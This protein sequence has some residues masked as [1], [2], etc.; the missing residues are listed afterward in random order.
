[1][2]PYASSRAAVRPDGVAR[3]ASARRVKRKLVPLPQARAR[4]TARCASHGILPKYV[5][6]FTVSA[7][8]LSANV[9]ARSSS[10]S[11]S[12]QTSVNT[13]ALCKDL[14]RRRA[15][16]E[17]STVGTPPK[18]MNIA[19]DGA[20]NSRAAPRGGARRRARPGRGCQDAQN[21]ENHHGGVADARATACR[22]RGKPQNVDVA[23]GSRKMSTSTVGIE[24][25]T[26][27]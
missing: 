23:A 5:A 14:S 27:S 12:T 18:R 15:Q 13:S 25:T 19:R 17:P 16:N 9:S 1:M 2:G 6:T 4:R 3:P 26:F 24:P 7:S 11:Y 8:T 20:H 10:Y 22:R 21:V